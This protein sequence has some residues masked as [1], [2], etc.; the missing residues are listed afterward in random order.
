MRLLTATFFAAFLLPAC[1]A[2]PNP[3]VGGTRDGGLDCMRQ[4]C[5]QGRPLDVMAVDGGVGAD[6]DAA[7]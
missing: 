7:P 2:N 3:P 6:G 4:P 5:A 1:G